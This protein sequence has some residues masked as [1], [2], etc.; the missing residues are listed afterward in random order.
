ML[1]GKI[2]TAMLYTCKASPAPTSIINQMAPTNSL[3]IPRVYIPARFWSEKWQEL[4]DQ[5]KVKIAHQLAYLE[6]ADVE[7]IDIKP[8]KTGRKPFAMAFVHI[9]EWHATEAAS[10]TVARLKERGSAKIVYDDPH[11][12]MILPWENKKM[13]KTTSEQH[14]KKKTELED[15]I[16]VLESALDQQLEMLQKMTDM[17]SK[18]GL[19]GNDQP[20]NTNGKRVR[21]KTEE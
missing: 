3:Y 20:V 16:K 9:K 6:I 5:A 17:M 19:Q 8:H 18:M 2:E 1:F 14:N 11:F 10:S 12:W 4:A 7:S 15:R 13:H 21:V